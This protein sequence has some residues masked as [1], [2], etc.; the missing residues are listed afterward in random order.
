MTGEMRA[1]MREQ[2]DGADMSVEVEVHKDGSAQG[3]PLVGQR[4]APAWSGSPHSRGARCLIPPALTC[5]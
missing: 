4:Q 5:G 1:K 2:M 3:A